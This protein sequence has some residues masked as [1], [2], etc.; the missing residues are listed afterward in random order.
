VREAL[1]DEASGLDRMDRPRACIL[2]LF[3][4]IDQFAGKIDFAFLGQPFMSHLPPDAPANVRRAKTYFRLHEENMKLLEHG[5]RLWMLSYGMKR[6]DD[7][8]P[9]VVERMRLQYTERR[10]QSGVPTS[11]PGK[12][13]RLT[14]TPLLSSVQHVA[15]GQ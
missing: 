14:R 3:A 1:R 15:T 12:A 2:K 10:H 7:W 5:I 8:A 11:D 4:R 6:E 9:I 13:R